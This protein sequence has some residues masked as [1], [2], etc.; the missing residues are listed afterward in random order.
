MPL[1]TDTKVTSSALPSGAA[2]AA[3]QDTGNATLTQVSAQLP[4]SL[5]A[6]GRLKAGQGAGS[7]TLVSY[8]TLVGAGTVA[9]AVL[10]LS[11]YDRVIVLA[12]NGKTV[13]TTTLSITFEDPVVGTVT[14][15][16][17][18]SVP[19]STA[20]MYNPWA[21]QFTTGA[22]GSAAFGVQY[23]KASMVLDAT[24][25]GSFIRIYGWRRS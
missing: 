3:K 8:V 22:N 7:W 16:S 14:A 17:G 18:T 19:A 20:I 21:G 6:N 15:S 10:D 13:A 4:A 11:D 5:D 2:T 24:N 25:A 12:K 1:N 23:F 9:T